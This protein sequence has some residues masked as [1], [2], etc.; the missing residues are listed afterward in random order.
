M[1]DDLRPIGRNTL[2]YYHFFQSFFDA[3]DVTS[4]FW[5]PILK[6]VGR[7]QLEFAGL[8]AKQGQAVLHW[9]QQMMQPHPLPDVIRLNAELWSAL[10]GQYMSVL[11]RVAAAAAAASGAVTSTVLPLPKRRHD[12]LIL[13]DRDDASAAERRVA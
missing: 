5:Q 4:L 12:T 6:S 7:T 8:Q 11:P 3:A 1:A 10:T 13:L 9:A 2:D